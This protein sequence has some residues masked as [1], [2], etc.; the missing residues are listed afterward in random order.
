MLKQRIITGLLMA[1]LLLGVMFFAPIIYAE[2]LLGIIIFLGL[3]EWMNLMKLSAVKPKILYILFFLAIFVILASIPFVFL[4]SI[5]VLLWLAVIFFLYG[6]FPKPSI[7]LNLPAKALW[8]CFILLPFGLAFDFLL[9]QE[10]H[11]L[12]LLFLLLSIASFDSGAYFVGSAWGRHKLAPHISPHKSL[13]GLL[14]GLILTGLTTALLSL[15]LRYSFDRALFM[16]VLCMLTG[17][18]SCL[19]DLLESAMKRSAGV[20]DSGVL[21]PGHGGI[22]DRIDA[23]TAGAPFFALMISIFY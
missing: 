15:Y 22:L 21:L 6:S 13:E 7:F 3:W 5:I 9:Q 12:L 11:A 10:Q 20:K 16:I 8:G 1:T 23:Y 18:I 14:G 4:M 19:G 2:I 17:L